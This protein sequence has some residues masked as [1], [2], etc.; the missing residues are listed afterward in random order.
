MP[1]GLNQEVVKLQ[2]STESFSTLL[3]FFHD[4][5]KPNPNRFFKIW[6]L[7]PDPPRQY[8]EIWALLQQQQQ[9]Q[10]QTFLLLLCCKQEVV[11]ELRTLI[12]AIKLFPSNG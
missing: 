1:H 7:I 3:L 9:Q 11:N 4:P 10:Q 8:M 5:S 2:G 12:V 6:V